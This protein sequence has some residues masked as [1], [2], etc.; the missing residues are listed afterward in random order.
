MPPAPFC[1]CL[2]HRPTARNT[3][4]WCSPPPS[5]SSALVATV[6]LRDRRC[7]V[8]PSAPQHGVPYIKHNVFW[9][10][11]KLVDIMVNNSSMR[12]FPTALGHSN[13]FGVPIDY[14]PRVRPWYVSAASGPKDVVIWCS[15]DYLG[16]GQNPK[17][18]KTLTTA[19]NLRYL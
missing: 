12:K 15:N 11:K 5:P 7:M 1:C 18:I 2:T 14:D 10:L 16:M 9:R 4:P 3:R 8:L 17:V 13:H 6:P 19:L